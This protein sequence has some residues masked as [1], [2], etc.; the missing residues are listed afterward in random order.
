[1]SSPI[2]ANPQ[3][4]SHKKTILR[5]RGAFYA[6]KIGGLITRY[7]SHVPGDW[8]LILYFAG[9][10]FALIELAFFYY[11]GKFYAVISVINLAIAYGLARI[12]SGVLKK[13]LE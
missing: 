4:L 1:M 11:S 13:M 10:Y 6:K 7:W 8:Q 12:S 9:A 3:P 5:E 2:K